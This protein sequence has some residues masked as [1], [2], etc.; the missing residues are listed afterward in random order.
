[1]HSNIRFFV[2]IIFILFSVIFALL[3]SKLEGID[4][5]K[6]I[7]RENFEDSSALNLKIS[8]EQWMGC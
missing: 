3:L 4:D 6:C 1:M 7:N 2:V 5:Y 8:L